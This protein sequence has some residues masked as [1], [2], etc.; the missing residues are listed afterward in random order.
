M[1]LTKFEKELKTAMKTG[2][3]EIV[4]LSKAEREKYRQAARVAL[5][6]SETIT[7]RINGGDLKALKRIALKAGKRYQTYIGELLHGHAAK[8]S[9]AA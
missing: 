3:Y 2:D 6:K 7:L 4:R 5:G 1:K 9:K 8:R